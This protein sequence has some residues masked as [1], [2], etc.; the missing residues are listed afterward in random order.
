MKLSEILN[1]DVDIVDPEMLHPSIKNN[2]II[3]RIPFYERKK[4]GLVS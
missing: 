2:V 3:N 4:Y 1:K